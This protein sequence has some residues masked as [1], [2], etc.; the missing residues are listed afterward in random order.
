M[1]G[2]LGLGL[3]FHLAG[4]RRI[5]FS[6]GFDRVGGAQ[7]MNVKLAISITSDALQNISQMN[8]TLH[9]GIPTTAVSLSKQLKLMSPSETQSASLSNARPVHYHCTS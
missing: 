6:G 4:W 5:W 7:D 9:C 1:S 3:H 2:S 8:P